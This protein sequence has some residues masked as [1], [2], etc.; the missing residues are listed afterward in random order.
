M[1]SG[2]GP[3]VG[4]AAGGPA[5]P[6]AGAADHA[7]PPPP[8]SDEELDD[9]LSAPSPAT[10][11]ALAR[12][13]GDVVVL[14]AGGKMGP[15]LAL[16]LRR[17]LDALGRED[18]A[19]GS[20]R[21][22][23]AVSRWTSD[24]AE[25]AL[26][27]AG[28]ETVRGDLTSQA[29]VARLPDAPNVI[30]MA[31]QKF[32]TRD[33]PSST[34]AMNVVAPVLCAERYAGSRIVAFSTGNVYPLVPVTGRGASEADAVAPVGEYAA[35]CVGRERVFEHFS[36]AR[37]TPVAIFRLNYA[38]DL[39]YGMLVDVAVRVL[40]GEPVSVAMGYANVIWQGDANRAALECLP[41]ASSPPFVVNVTGPAVLSVR[42]TAR[43]FGRIFGRE[44]VIVGEEA[45]DALLSD[46]TRMRLTLSAPTVPEPQL[47]A[48]VADW[49]QRGGTLLGK[50]TKFEVRDGGY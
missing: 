13:P 16:M 9:L 4:A 3:G 19:G 41:R 2:E 39:R 48:W 6:T 27:A 10:R 29:D 26:R 42:E 12:C 22:V 24:A 47:L 7:T 15:T 36:R 46:T 31:G 38:V 32:G 14:G 21:R 25:H 49:V 28:V 17:T 37:A 44:P 18:R 23:Y 50:P 45:P 35:S 1:S 11:D 34:W 33:T 8:R 43:E 40:R 30:Y 20:S 5:A